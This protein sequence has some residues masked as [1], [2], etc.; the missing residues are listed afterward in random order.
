LLEA[1]RDERSGNHNRNDITGLPWNSLKTEN[2]HADPKQ[3]QVRPEESV[4]RPI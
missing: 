4:D 2:K 1:P 3:D